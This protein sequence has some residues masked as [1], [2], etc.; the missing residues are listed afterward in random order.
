MKFKFLALFLLVFTEITFA[1]TGE[2][3]EF[4]TQILE[5]TGGKIL[6]PKDWFYNE[7]HN[8][9]AYKWIISVENTAG[10]KP[11]NTGV[12]IQTVVDVSKH[13]GKSA[14][15]FIL[16]FVSD[17]KK[18]ATKIIGTCEEKD[19]SLFTRICLETEE[20]ENHISYSLFWGTSGM[21]IALVSI[22]GTTKELWKTHQKTFNKM[23]EFELIDM[24]RF[25]K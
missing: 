3:D 12:T 24:K 18:V 25:E 21:D 11:Y 5:P 2:S 7:F 4:V 8:G 16:D 22:S 17:R 23:R 20:G 15:D 10:S 9:P 6:R 19:T 1:T 14:K 13:T